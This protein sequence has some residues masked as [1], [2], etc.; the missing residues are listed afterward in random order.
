ML[1]VPS[2][3]APKAPAVAMIAFQELVQQNPVFLAP[4]W[5]LRNLEKLSYNTA[6]FSDIN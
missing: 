3:D 6:C 5:A 2:D 1:S 4:K